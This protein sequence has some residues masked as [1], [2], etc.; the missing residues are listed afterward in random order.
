MTDDATPETAA[1]EHEPEGEERARPR[2]PLLV[3]VGVL[4]LAVGVSG[5]LVF[6]ASLPTGAAETPGPRSADVGFARDMQVHHAQAVEMS[7]IVRERTDDPE[8]RTIA[9]DIAL[10]QQ[11]QIGQMYAW[12]DTW[13]HPQR[14]AEP[15]MTWMAHH[16]SGS[17]DQ[18]GEGERHG[19][20]EHHAPDDSEPTRAMPGMATP[21]QLR[22]LDD[23]TGR[24]AE[25]LF[26]R[27][28]IEHHES[29]IDMAQAAVEQAERSEVRQ[30]ARKMVD[31]QQVEIAAM[32]QMIE[33]RSG[34]AE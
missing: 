21:E 5:G 13:G 8:V 24:D 1:S 34:N 11:Q 17:D 2:W 16:S 33:D 3:A 26:L 23:S 10:T 19:E 30:L 27:L 7:T 6:G 12:L 4:A 14:T 29:G 25:L 9:L 32:R 28:M 15:P 31:G 22:R 18:G 20:G